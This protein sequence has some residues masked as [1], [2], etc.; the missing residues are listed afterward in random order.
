ME[1]GKW[2]EVVDR[3]REGNGRTS[4]RCTVIACIAVGIVEEE[5]PEEGSFEED[6]AVVGVAPGGLI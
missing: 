6:P 2:E 5:V 3:R 1:E 4:L